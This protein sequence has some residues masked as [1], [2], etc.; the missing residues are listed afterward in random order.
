[1]TDR[2][3]I[4]PGNGSGP[5]LQPRSLHGA[6]TRWTTRR[7]TNMRHGVSTNDILKTRGVKLS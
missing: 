3:D 2:Y 5:F 1:M 4:R 7:N 6:K